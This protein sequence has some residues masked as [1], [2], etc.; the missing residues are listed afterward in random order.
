MEPFVEHS[1][2]HIVLRWDTT[3]LGLWKTAFWLLPEAHH[4]NMHPEQ[5]TT[6][7]R[8]VQH[9][10]VWK[11]NS[12]RTTVSS[13][14]TASVT[15]LWMY[16]RDVVLWRSLFFKQNRT[17]ST[18]KTSPHQCFVR[19]APLRTFALGLFVVFRTK[20]QKKKRRLIFAPTHAR[21]MPRLAEPRFCVWPAVLKNSLLSRIGQGE[22]LTRLCVCVC[23]VVGKER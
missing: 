23:V 22:N 19:F 4:S 2:A 9:A 10:R 7:S 17:L 11:R 5:I 8:T 1:I 12:S 13:Y 20:K 21:G 15:M 18:V 3:F 14:S 6:Q 16:C